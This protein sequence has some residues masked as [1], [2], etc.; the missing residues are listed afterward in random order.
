M[1][2]L[3]LSE[4]RIVDILNGS[5]NSNDSNVYLKK[6]DMIFLYAETMQDGKLTYLT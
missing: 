5:N 3:S 1:L 4:D 2:Q 6:D